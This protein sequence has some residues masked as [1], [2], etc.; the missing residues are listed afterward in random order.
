MKKGPRTNEEQI[1]ALREKMGEKMSAEAEVMADTFDPDVVTLAYKLMRANA[2]KGK[3][4][5]AVTKLL[6]QLPS[7]NAKAIR[8]QLAGVSK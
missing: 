6:D 3:L 8:S 2:A 7:E 4:P 1:K 5:K